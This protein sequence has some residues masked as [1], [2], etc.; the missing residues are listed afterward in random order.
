MGPIS[1]RAE[2]DFPDPYTWGDEPWLIDIKEWTDYSISSGFK[3]YEDYNSKVPYLEI[4]GEPF[5]ISWNDSALTLGL[6]Q[7]FA[8]ASILAF[9]I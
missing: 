2:E 7:T 1:A 5:V 9:L 3:I 4:D 6:A 8:F